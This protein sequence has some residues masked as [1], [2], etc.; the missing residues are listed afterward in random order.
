MLSINCDIIKF[1]H[2]ALGYMYKN[3]Y[4]SFACN[5]KL[6]TAQIHIVRK[7]YK[8]LVNYYII[9]YS[10]L[11]EMYKSQ[12][13]MWTQVNI[14]N[15]IWIKVAK[16]LYC[17]VLFFWSPKARKKLKTYSLE[18]HTYI[19][20]KTQRNPRESLEYVIQECCYFWWR[21]TG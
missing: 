19:V 21:N 15:E 11:L 12:L 20:S 17:I 6:E 1:L 9:E 5:S 8:Y 18:V 3:I 16:N 14:R 13:H 4:S 10:I 2:C 7:R